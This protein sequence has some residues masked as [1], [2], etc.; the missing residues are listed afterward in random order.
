MYKPCHHMMAK[1]KNNLKPKEQS[2]FLFVATARDCAATLEADIMHI[3]NAL[4]KVK[5]LHILVVE[6]DSDDDSLQILA[7][8]KNKIK[9]FDFISM[10]RL[11]EKYP[12]RTKR[13]EVCRNAYMDKINNDKIYQKLDYVLI[14]DLD[15]VNDLLTKKSIASCWQT[16]IEWD[17]CSANQDAPY[18]DVWPLRHKYWSPN[19]F[20]TQYRYMRY[21]QGQAMDE[22]EEYHIGRRFRQ[23]RFP[24]D[25]AWLEVDSS[26]GGLAIYKAASLKGCHYVGTTPQGG[27]VSEHVHFHKMMRDKGCRLFINPQMI[28]TTYNEHTQYLKLSDVQSAMMKWDVYLQRLKGKGADQLHHTIH[29]RLHRNTLRR[30]FHKMKADYIEYMQSFKYSAAGAPI[31][32]LEIFLKIISKFMMGEQL[33]K[34]I[35]K[36]SRTM[37]VKKLEL[38]LKIV[39]REKTRRK[40]EAKLRMIRDR[41]KR[42]EHDFRKSMALDALIAADATKNR[43]ANPNVKPKE[44]SVVL[45]VAVVRD[46]APTLKADIMRLKKAVGEV[47]ELHFFIVE[48]DSDDDTL[49]VLTQLKNKIKNFDFISMGRLRDQYPQKTKRLEICRNAYLAHMN[50]ARA[51]SIDYVMVAD[52]DGVNDRLTRKS[53]ASCWDGAIEWDMCSANQSA[54]YYDV[55]ALRHDYW[56]P[57]DVE[58]QHKFMA[59]FMDADKSRKISIALRQIRLPKKSAWVEVESS[60]GGAAIYKAAAFKGCKYAGVTSQGE[61]INEHVALHKMMRDKGCRLFINPQMIN[62][63]YKERVDYC[64][65]VVAEKIARQ[66]DLFLKGVKILARGGRLR[67]KP[68]RALPKIKSKHAPLF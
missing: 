10:G 13:L 52:L 42:E 14:A 59:Q 35:S 40:L 68:Q 11:R 64:G 63:Q 1:R 12:L 67:K 39:S 37:R 15:G 58:A 4:G 53:I 57:N 33:R 34:S 43:C 56:S 19:D 41:I 20:I 18:Y 28:N 32:K 65:L 38:Y 45:V 31:K 2:I 51:Q 30:M 7:Q 60:F 55:W 50:D 66:I 54:P 27:E 5:E 16:D 46:G 36:K 21:L 6:S 44:Q 62:T 3:K 47:K 25:S 24:Q 22:G 49:H 8:L 26:F 9:N 17:M 23:V 61:E 29:Y 48:S